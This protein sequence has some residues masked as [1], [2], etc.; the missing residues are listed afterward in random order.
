M[1]DGDYRRHRFRVGRG[2][3]TVGREKGLII[4]RTIKRELKSETTRTKY[5]GVEWHGYGDKIKIMR[6]KPHT[7]YYTEFS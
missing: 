2:R 7:L 5:L 1:T 6:W 4:R 3:S